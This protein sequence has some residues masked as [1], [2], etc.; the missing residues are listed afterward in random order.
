MFNIYFRWRQKIEVQSKQLA[1]NNKQTSYIPSPLR[2]GNSIAIPTYL[3]GN[4]RLKDIEDIG[5]NKTEPRKIFFAGISPD[6]TRA[7]V[8]EMR[9]MLKTKVL[10][11]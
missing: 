9:A 1:T 7:M 11:Q 6:I 3:K 5:N 8:E 2:T 10:R 4:I